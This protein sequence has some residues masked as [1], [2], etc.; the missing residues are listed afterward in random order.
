MSFIQSYLIIKLCPKG[1]HN[2]ARPLFCCR[3]LDLGPVTLNLDR[4]LDVL[5]VYLHTENESH[6]KVIT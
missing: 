5:K 3:D 4:D 2:C 6:S 1:A